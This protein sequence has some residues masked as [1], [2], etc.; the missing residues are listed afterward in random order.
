MKVINFNSHLPISRRLYHVQ[1]Q[2]FRK[3]GVRHIALL[4]LLLVLMCPSTKA[5]DDENKVMTYLTSKAQFERQQSDTIVVFNPGSKASNSGCYWDDDENA[6]RFTGTSDLQKM[7]GIR[8]LASATSGPFSK[9]N[10]TTGFT[11]GWE[12]KAN[13]TTSATWGR[14][15]DATIYDG[16]GYT[17]S[18]RL[19]IIR[20]RINS[21]KQNGH[22]QISLA[23]GQ[24][25]S[26][27]EAEVYFDSQSKWDSYQVVVDHSG[28]LKVYINGVGQNQVNNKTQTDGILS[29]IKQ[30]ELT[31]GNSYAGLI[32]NQSHFQFDGWI[33]NFQIAGTDLVQRLKLK[34][35]VANGEILANS[36]PMASAGTLVPTG[37]TVELSE[38]PATGYHLDWTTV[39]YQNVTINSSEL[40]VT[41]E[42]PTFPMPIGETVLTGTFVQNQYFIKYDWNLN[43]GTIDGN[44]SPAALPNSQKLHFG[45][46]TA[47]STDKLKKDGNGWYYQLKGWATSPSGGVVY[48]PGK[49]YAA[50]EVTALNGTK[51][52][53]T[54][55]TL[56]A[57]WDLKKYTVKV[58]PTISG[59]TVKISKEESGAG[60]DE[61]KDV[62]P[63]T[64]IYITTTID[65]DN[66]YVKLKSLSRSDLSGVIDG[67]YYELNNEKTNATQTFQITSGNADILISA[68]FNGDKAVTLISDVTDGV[69]TVNGELVKT[70]ENAV[71]IGK[72]VNIVVTPDKEEGLNY[73]K[74]R[75]TS[76]QWKYGT[77]SDEIKTITSFT[78]STSTG[79]Y[80]VSLDDLD[81]GIEVLP[82]FGD[83]I[84]LTGTNPESPEDLTLT[85]ND[86]DKTQTWTGSAM[87]VPY[88]LKKN[89]TA[90]GENEYEVSFSDN[91]NAGWATGVVTM[92][93][94]EKYW[95]YVNFPKTFHI[96]YDLSQA[97]VQVKELVYNTQSQQPTASDVTVTMGEGD[98][99]VTVPSSDYT[100]SPTAG[101]VVGSY[102]ITV[103]PN[104]GEEYNSYDPSDNPKTS[105]YK[106]V[107]ADLGE[108]VS[109][110]TATGDNITQ[111]VSTSATTTASLNFSLSSVTLNVN[112]VQANLTSGTHY[113]TAYVDVDGREYVDNIPAN[114]FGKIYLA[115]MPANGNANFVGYK[116]TD[117]YT[118]FQLPLEITERQ[119]STYYNDLYNLTVPSDASETITAYCV[120]GVSGNSVTLTD[121]TYIPKEVPVLLYRSASSYDNSTT[122]TYRLDQVPMQAVPTHDAN[123]FKGVPTN[124]TQTL[125]I[126]GKKVYVLNGNQFVLAKTGT[127]PANRCYLQLDES[128]AGSR[129]RLSIGGDGDATGIED[130]LRDLQQEQ[131][132]DLNGRK[133]KGPQ[134]KGVY[135][136]NGR[137]VIIK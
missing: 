32:K 82:V 18:N 58:D 114:T 117:K 40:G 99:K 45:A 119:W 127:I 67:A 95:G 41:A 109:A 129:Q 51:D 103:T 56:Y 133:L 111:D 100:I 126:S 112:D 28:L 9:V 24:K 87:T 73:S 30:F 46:F 53:E 63:N 93:N 34:E 37:S 74:K 44:S 131:W 83:K 71:F 48:E 1:P 75:L 134:G 68:I 7:N 98:G 64:T 136:V 57:V 106:I 101:T 29:V 90:P 120:T 47:A 86:G 25:Q 2:I 113:R 42:N 65:V 54:S 94:N 122:V 69:V 91:I 92:K 3:G 62:T 55:A 116:L 22:S 137:K 85:I 76:F 84:Q 72:K 70:E 60:S 108:Y 102:S 52:G 20:C 89:G 97:S 39:K 35:Q 4:F 96:K 10:S 26:I 11:I 23:Y 49:A 110:Y 105:T 88:T 79:S 43:G 17:D 104:T 59:G 19:H 66:G 118:N 115:V 5:A 6:C 125:P 14:F 123:L 21:G 36:I 107:P 135:I 16:S 77:G 38:K 130:A 80:T 8:I 13:I 81:R 121:A 31:I 78:Y 27:A 128:T 15:F 61:I 132:Y 12:A 33:K 50:G 124:G